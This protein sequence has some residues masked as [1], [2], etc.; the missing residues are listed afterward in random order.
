M[1][2]DSLLGHPASLGGDVGWAGPLDPEACRRLACDGTLTRVLVTR[3]P[4][5]H[6]HPDPSGQAPPGPHGPGGTDGLAAQL[7]TAMTRLPPT[8]ARPRPSR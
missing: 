8:W 5:D 1:D 4:P 2:L 3:Q 6:H 7:R